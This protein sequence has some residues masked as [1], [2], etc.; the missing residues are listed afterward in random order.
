MRFLANENFP[1]VSIK[2][3]RDAGHEV[4]AVIEIMSG[5]KDEQV[6]EKAHDASQIILT[7]DSD[8]GE[9]IFKHKLPVPAGVIYL[10]LTPLT[11]EE[12]ANFILNL[13]AE[14]NILLEGKFTVARRD[15]IRQRSLPK[16]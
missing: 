8:Y 3:L 12:P 7:F 10:R 2:K 16:S 6:L 1:V 13:L 15:R 5:A 4:T 14:K 9:L 11:P